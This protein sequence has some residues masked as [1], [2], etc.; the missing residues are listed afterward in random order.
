MCRKS[1]TDQVIS[2]NKV[3][4]L[5]FLDIPVSLSFLY[6]MQHQASLHQPDS[7]QARALCHVV[8]PSLRHRA[9]PAA[10]FPSSIC[11]PSRAPYLPLRRLPRPAPLL[12]IHRSDRQRNFRTCVNK[13][14][15]DEWLVMWSAQAF[16]KDCDRESL[17]VWNCSDG[18]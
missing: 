14:K 18:F 1:V 2:E 3:C 6:R 7:Q 5:L 16:F 12:V 11:A 13:K 9:T 4:K 17:N 8:P 10:E 15:T